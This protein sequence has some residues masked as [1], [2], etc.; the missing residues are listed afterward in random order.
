MRNPSIIAGSI[1]L[2][3]MA[4]VALFGPSLLESTLFEGQRPGMRGS[5]RPYQL[6][7]P[8]HPIG[9]DGD[10]RDGLMVF[11]S[12]IWPSLQIGVIA[13]ATSTGSGRRDRLP[14]R[15]C[16]RAAGHACHASSSTWCW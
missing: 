7:S 10:G 11:V 14:R 4:I 9:T 6:D 2:A 13:G 1:M 12:S 16:P 15:L 5:Y 3:L 8:E